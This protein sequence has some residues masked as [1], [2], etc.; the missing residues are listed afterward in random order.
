MKREGIKRKK[1]YLKKK[2]KYFFQFFCCSF[3]ARNQII[4]LFSFSPIHFNFISL[5]I[6]CI[7]IIS[8]PSKLNKFTRFHLFATT[9]FLKLV[10]VCGLEKYVRGVSLSRIVSQDIGLKLKRHFE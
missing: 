8:A 1:Q 3:Q 6:C 2:Q 7:L 4:K 5:Y 10:L 9:F